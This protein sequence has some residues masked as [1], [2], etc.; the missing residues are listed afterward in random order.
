MKK[1]LTESLYGGRVYVFIL[2][3]FSFFYIPVVPNPP[4]SVERETGR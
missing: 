4:Q 1:D 2:S 3:F